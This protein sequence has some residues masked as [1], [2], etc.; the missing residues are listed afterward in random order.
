M[1]R[2]FNI[3]ITD[4][5][6]QGPYNIYYNSVSTSTYATRVSTSL[7]ATGVTY[8]DLSVGT[9]VA[10]Q[11]PDTATTII[12]DNPSC[13]KRITYVLP[14]ARRTFPNCTDGVL[15]KWALVKNVNIAN[16]SN[17]KSNVV[18]SGDVKILQENEFGDIVRAELVGLPKVYVTPPLVFRRQQYSIIISDCNGNLCCF[19][20]SRIFNIAWISLLYYAPFR[21]IF[22]PS[23]IVESGSYLEQPPPGV[24]S[25]P[26]TR[27]NFCNDYFEL[28][29]NKA[30]ITF[31]GTFQSPCSNFT[32]PPYFI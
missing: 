31:D 7:P 16:P 1:P 21:T 13:N 24:L 27:Y 2:S 28:I 30:F 14:P 10:V 8:N 12:L 23:N 15:Y 26:W 22:F 17:V 32:K 3:K 4:G 5:T 9:G 11:V 20:W 29:P 19:V 25:K 6:A 18:R